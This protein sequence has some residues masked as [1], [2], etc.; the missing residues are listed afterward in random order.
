MMSEPKSQYGRRS[1]LRN[2]AIA[3]LAAGSGVAAGRGLISS[4]A[5]AGGPGF[6]GQATPLVDVVDPLVIPSIRLMTTDGHISAPG[7]RF[8]GPQPHPIYS[9]GFRDVDDQR[10]HAAGG[11]LNK[12]PGDLVTKYRGKVIATSPTIVVLEG[13]EMAIVLTNLG[14]EG[15]PDLDDGHSLHWHGFRNATAVFD[16]VPETSVAVPPGRD[17]PYFYDLKTAD[18]PGQTVGSAGTYM[19]HCHFEDVEHVQMGMT[20]VIFVEPRDMYFLPDGITPKPRVKIAYN[21]NSAGVDSSFA[22]EFAIL[23]NEID[24]A[25]HDNLEALQEF[26]W[27]DYNP[28]YWTLNGRCYPD[29]VIPQITPIE[30]K[31]PVGEFLDMPLVPV[32]DDEKAEAEMYYQR[33]SSLIQVREGERVLLRLANLG[34]EI[35]SLDLV[36]VGEMR[37]IAHDAS[38]LIGKAGDN[39]L[40]YTSR[41]I[42]LGPGEARDAI[43][44]VPAYDDLNA[45]VDTLAARMSPAKARKF[46]RYLLKSRAGD[47]LHNNGEVDPDDGPS[48]AKVSDTHGGMVT[49]IW[50]YPTLLDA[51]GLGQDGLPDQDSVNETFPTLV[52]PVGQV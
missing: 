50:V 49:E 4:A 26:V 46:N 27:S 18:E 23:T 43:F 16:G 2:G 25:P 24:P 31:A 7:R 1:F 21:D 35:H 38:L 42:E 28:K 44:T 36:G 20:G 12:N 41:R 10:L 33:N 13:E 8:S 39:D 19:Y 52:V 11:E 45:E 32:T 29:T 40:T 47:R 17:L 9:F 15:R 48:Y 14:F 5:A 30:Q 6:L 37:V 34:Y 22:R 51:P 3:S